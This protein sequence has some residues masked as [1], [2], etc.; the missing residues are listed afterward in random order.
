MKR[1]FNRYRRTNGINVN[2][3]FHVPLSFI[4][5]TKNR[6]HQRRKRERKLQHAVGTIVN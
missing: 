2:R 5:E 6:K 4:N 3:L 1:Q